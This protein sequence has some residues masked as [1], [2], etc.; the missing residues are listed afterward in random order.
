MKNLK[1][2]DVSFNGIQSED[3][4]SMIEILKNCDWPNLIEI[5]LDGCSIDN[6]SFV[7]LE[8]FLRKIPRIKELGLGRLI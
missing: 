8:E 2:I 7:K 6:A 3:S 4:N 5:Y 1:S